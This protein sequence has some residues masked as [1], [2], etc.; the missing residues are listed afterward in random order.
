MQLW[1]RSPLAPSLS[2]CIISTAG[3]AFLYSMLM[4]SRLMLQRALPC[5]PSKAATPHG[6][7]RL[8]ARKIHRTLHSRYV[9]RFSLPTIHLI[10]NHFNS[11]T[12]DPDPSRDSPL[13]IHQIQ[14]LP[15][16][17]QGPSS[18]RLPPPSPTLPLSSPHP[19]RRSRDVIP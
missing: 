1:E 8:F 10:A 4:R 7:I 9:H 3:Y 19:R 14:F 17:K 13:E 12:F 15:L 6:S 2:H 5:S 11:D 18:R 16:R